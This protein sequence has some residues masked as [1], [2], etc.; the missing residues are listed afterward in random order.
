MQPPECLAQDKVT[1]KA[2]IW[3]VGVLLHEIY[4]GQ[5][6]LPSLDYDEMVALAKSGLMTPKPLPAACP[7]W[8]HAVV[9]ACFEP[10]P[11]N[12]ASAAQ[13]LEIVSKAL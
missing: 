1:T 10:D 13:L 7:G 8:A 9:T 3:S 6:P 5:E 2:D 4:T 12:R 11:T